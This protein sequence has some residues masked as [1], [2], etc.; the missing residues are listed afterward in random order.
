MDTLPDDLLSKVVQCV[1]RRCVDGSNREPETWLSVFVNVT[2]VSKTWRNLAYDM[3][4]KHMGP[5]GMAIAHTTFFYSELTTTRY[6]AYML[7]PKDLEAWLMSEMVCLAKQKWFEDEN[8]PVARSEL[9]ALLDPAY[10]STPCIRFRLNATK[11]LFP[12][13][14]MCKTLFLQQCTEHT[15]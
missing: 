8:T 3:S 9:P 5:Q 15:W 4:M 11:L 7:K 13:N 12:V 14:P 1:V 10:P 2:T 6:T